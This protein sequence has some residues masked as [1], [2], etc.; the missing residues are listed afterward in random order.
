MSQQAVTSRALRL[1]LVVVVRDGDQILACRDHDTGVWRLPST[2]WHAGVNPVEAVRKLLADRA[3]A[4]VS[5]TLHA[6]V[7]L[8]AT[9]GLLLFTAKP[10]NVPPAVRAGTR[11]CRWLNPQ[12]IPAVLPPGDQRWVSLT[13]ASGRRPTAPVTGRRPRSRH[14]TTVTTSTAVAPQAG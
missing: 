6:S 11:L 8:S 4:T 10:L 14:L 1:R 13:S 12:S 2:P 7:R 9:A 3:A 5:P